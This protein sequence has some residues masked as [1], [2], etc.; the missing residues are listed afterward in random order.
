[1][2][3]FNLSRGNSSDEVEVNPAQAEIV[4]CFAHKMEPAVHLHRILLRLVPE[5]TLIAFLH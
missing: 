3:N 5:I 2:L 1:L 4:G